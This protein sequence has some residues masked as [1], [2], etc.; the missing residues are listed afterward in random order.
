MFRFWVYI[1]FVI[2]AWSAYAE[3]IVIV[4]FGSQ[5]THLIAQRL[6]RIGVQTKIVIPEKALEE[7]KHCLGMILSGGPGS[8][9]EDN[10]L[11]IPFHQTYSNLSIDRFE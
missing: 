6:R 5:T 11:T 9:Y 4:D 2:A 3:E 10:A 8:V 1:A 7:S